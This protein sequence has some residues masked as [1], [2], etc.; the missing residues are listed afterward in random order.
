MVKGSFIEEQRRRQIVDAAIDTIA[1]HGAANASFSKIATRIGI[2]PSLISYHFASRAELVAA[3]ANVLNADL[4][5]ALEQTTEGADSY[6][7]A[8]RCMVEGF[9][10]Y[11]DR[12]RNQMLAML[13]LTVGSS[14][15]DREAAA[16]LNQEHA[17]AEWEEF[18]REGQQAGE[19]RD[20]DLRTVALCRHALLAGVPREL[21]ANPDLDVE[22]FAAHVADFAERAIGKA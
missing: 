2:S 8:A 18:L 1:E 5:A 10:R 12:N 11:A 4:D 15:S 19:F 17:I 9:V 13:Q 16:V 21:F 7:A 6:L 22:R 3:V 14:P 20:F